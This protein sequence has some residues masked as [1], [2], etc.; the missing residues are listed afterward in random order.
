[1][2][3]GTP[4]GKRSWKRILLWTV[5]VLGL[6]GAVC[7]IW[8]QS[9][10]YPVDQ[11]AKQVLQEAQVERVGGGLH[12]EAQ[13]P[14]ATLIFYTGAFVNP[15][16]YSG[17]GKGLADGG[18]DVYILSS[19]FN[20]PVLDGAHAKQLVEKEKIDLPSLY[21]GGHSLG[22]VMASR[23]AKDMNP[24]GLILLASYPDSKTD[25]SQTSLRVL[26]ITADQDQVMK[27]DAFR[28]AQKRLPSNTSYVT[29][30]G[31]N[32]SGFAWYGQQ[33]GDGQAAISQ[34]IQMREIVTQILAFTQE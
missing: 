12:F 4:K 9:Q 3:K 7:S 24:A 13:K 27:E 34:E 5:V 10:S 17:L 18:V 25:L 6:G 30:R 1:M 19:P 11:K 14:R 23:S 2:K 15:E 32:H 16:S 21:L 31:G 29:I 8:L 33:K 26:S 28:E 20:L 22:G